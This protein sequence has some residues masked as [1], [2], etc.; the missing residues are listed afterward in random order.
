MLTSIM[1]YSGG[2]T[3]LGQNGIYPGERPWVRGNRFE[4]Q[5]EADERKQ[6]EQM[7][8][9]LESPEF[10][11]AVKDLDSALKELANKQAAQKAGRNNSQD[12]AAEAAL[13][14]LLLQHQSARQSLQHPDAKEISVPSTHT[15][16]NW[17]L[18]GT[19]ALAAS[20]VL[21][22]IGLLLGRRLARR[23]PEAHQGSP[24]SR[25][26]SV[27][28]QSPE[29]MDPE[30]AMTPPE[31]SVPPVGMIS[32]EELSRRG[33]VGES[34]AATIQGFRSI[35]WG[36]V[37]PW[38]VAFTDKPW[39]LLWVRWLLM[40]GLF[41][42]VTSILCSDQ[43]GTRPLPTVCVAGYVALFWALGLRSVVK[44]P[45]VAAS[46]TIA[47]L[48]VQI[49]IFV[50]LLLLG[51]RVEWLNNVFAAT[52]S[53]S[54][55]WRISAIFLVWTIAQSVLAG[56]LLWWQQRLSGSIRLFYLGSI[57]G[58]ALAAS[59]AVARYLNDDWFGSYRGAS[60][61][62]FRFAPLPSLLASMVVGLLTGGILAAIISIGKT[63]P[64]HSRRIAV[65][66][67]LAAAFVMTLHSVALTTWAHSIVVAASTL[68]F[69]TYLRLISQT[70][71]ASQPAQK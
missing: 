30:K 29:R 68:G 54:A 35:H 13:R 61:G 40:F 41:P 34:V 14:D 47:V 6:Q 64:V 25:R 50:S 18:V 27:V 66:G 56:A 28:I 57:S 1:L 39:D 37:F 24:Q 3:V 17:T 49:S 43:D 65:V 11:G 8:K 53:S 67:T 45:S 19:G 9:L 23:T 59:P 71:T 31:L 51:T 32:S 12:P 62:A 52:A 58:M 20:F 42:S 10:Q 7:R 2:G 63:T 60:I 36:A 55:F 16:P 33:N 70:A 46:S 15:S 69:V 26:P 5:A 48:A 22:G 38:H 21:L 4:T 44:P